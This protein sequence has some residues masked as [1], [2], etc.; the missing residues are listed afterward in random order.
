MEE[1]NQDIDV[2]QEFYVIVTLVSKQQEVKVWWAGTS[3]HFLP[4]FIANP[5][6]GYVAVRKLQIGNACPCLVSTKGK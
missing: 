2:R 1:R 3:N 5:R 6:K 4:A